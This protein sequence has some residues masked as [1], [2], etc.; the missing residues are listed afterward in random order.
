M[1]IALL[2]P[3]YFL[4]HYT[5]A[6]RLCLN[7]VTNFIWFTYHFFSMPVLF[8]TLFAPWHKIHEKYRRGF[9]PASLV[10]TFII[11]TIMRAVGFVVRIVVLVF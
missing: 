10:E 1:P 3:E 6:L 2:I 9:H 11:N 7:V 4:W 5:T 8:R